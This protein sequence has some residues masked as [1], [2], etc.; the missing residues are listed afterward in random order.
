MK[1]LGLKCVASGLG[2]M[3]CGVSIARAQE[4]IHITPPSVGRVEQVSPVGGA[5]AGA[6]T[7]VAPKPSDA[8]VSEVKAPVNSV[9]D[10]VLAKLRAHEMTAQDVWQS[11][12]LN[13]DD[14]LY[15]IENKVDDWGGFYWDKDLKL[16]RELESLLA[17]SGGEKI[18]DSEKLS[19]KV[20]LWLSDYYGSMKDER[21]IALAESVLSEFK[22]PV[23]SDKDIALIFQ[24]AERLGWYY[25]QKGDYQK[26]AESWE[27]VAD[28]TAVKGWWTGD[29]QMIASLRYLD[30][31]TA[32]SKQKSK[33][34][35]MGLLKDG[36]ERPYG[37]EGLVM[38]V[39]HCLTAQRIEWAREFT[40]EATPYSEQ[41]ASL[42]VLISQLKGQIFY[43]EGNFEDA[44]TQLAETVT[45]YQKIDQTPSAVT[46]AIFFQ[47]QS[48][49]E[50]IKGK[51]TST[52]VSEPKQI[53]LSIETS[54]KKTIYRTAKIIAYHPLSLII[55]S[56]NS[57]LQ[58]HFL[59]DWQKQN[60]GVTLEKQL[61]IEIS[62][63][64]LQ[65]PL[66]ATLILQD[67]ENPT[68]KWQIPVS[69]DTNVQSAPEEAIPEEA[70]NEDR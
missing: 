9:V 4:Q 28:L 35:L 45:A 15:L 62:F 44:Q 12:V 34:I 19:P 38:A 13:V 5:S 59:N 17:Q 57:K 22:E 20:R 53:Q 33:K 30:D 60:D 52:F 47:A 55:T 41:D 26:A 70:I 3:L 18:K 37:A 69:A 49:L 27:R 6:V 24:G 40:D 10:A 66:E 7:Q 56:D 42:T 68:N 2:L 43:H 51:Q 14:L 65:Q 54:E 16:R 23:K 21:A 48:M 39:N 31:N 61:L 50:K 29:A 36:Q 64:A 32:A 58:A 11:G 67:R 8:G 1:A 63:D 25:Y 46:T